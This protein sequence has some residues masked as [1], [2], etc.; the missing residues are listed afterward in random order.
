MEALGINVPGL[1]AQLVNFTLLFLVLRVTLYKPI[2]GMLDQRAQRI[3]QSM[4][5]A[6][7]IQREMARMEAEVERRLDEAR[8]EGQNLVAQA[9]QVGER[10][11]EEARAE[12]RR[13]AEAI[14]TRARAEIH[15]ERDEAI[16][17][18][19]EQFADLTILAASKVINQSLDK[20]AHQRLIEEVLAESTGL[21]S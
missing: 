8:R 2:M 4:E 14:V 1:L 17:Q 9:M 18:L 3:R 6:E 19:R 5:Q 7:Q 20:A 21:R 12:A 16:A 11:R 10:M 15:I 13:E